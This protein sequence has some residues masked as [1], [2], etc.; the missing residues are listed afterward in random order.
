M[1]TT[2]ISELLALPVFLSHSDTHS[3]ALTHTSPSRSPGLNAS[4]GNRLGVDTGLGD[5]VGEGVGV[6]SPPP[7]KS[8]VS[9]REVEQDEMRLAGMR[10]VVR[11][12][13]HMD[14]QLPGTVLPY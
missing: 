5:G 11:A 8:C 12:L 7:I 2:T 13:R 9:L 1:T 4:P 6:D 3:H 14:L 10:R